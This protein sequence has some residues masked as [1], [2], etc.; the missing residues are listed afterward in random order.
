MHK[1]TFKLP[2][3]FIE[4]LSATIDSAFLTSF[5]Q[6]DVGDDDDFV[7]L[8]QICLH[9]SPLLTRHLLSENTPSNTMLP[10]EA[11]LSHKMRAKLANTC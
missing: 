7:Q 4:R 8:S 1:S 5:S 3:P 9:H 2:S 6:V 11:T 10:I